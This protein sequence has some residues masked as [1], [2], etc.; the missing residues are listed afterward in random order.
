MSSFLTTAFT[1]FVALFI[2]VPIF[3]AL[4][5]VFGLYTIVEEG[6]CHVYVLFGKVIAILNEPGPYLLWV[7]LGPRGLIVNWLGRWE[8][9]TDGTIGSLR[10]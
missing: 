6:R 1:V 3:A 9:L 2:L 7:K 5:R 10:T 8:K 4:T